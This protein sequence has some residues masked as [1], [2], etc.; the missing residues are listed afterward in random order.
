MRL[1]DNS[2][3]TIPAAVMEDGKYVAHNAD[4]TYIFSAKELMIIKGWGWLVRKE[5]M[6][7]FVE[8]RPRA[9]G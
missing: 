1:E 8:P 2:E 6:V 7:A 5:P 9:G 3:I 4:V